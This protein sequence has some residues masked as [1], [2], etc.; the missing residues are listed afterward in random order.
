MSKWEAD[1]V[2]VVDLAGTE[3]PDSRTVIRCKF[4]L[5]ELADE[6]HLVFG[7]L[8]D[9]PYHARLVAQFCSERRIPSGWEHEPD[10]YAL[11]TANARVCGGGYLAIDPACR[12]AE[13]YGRSNA[14]GPYDK[15]AMHAVVEHGPVFRGLTV[16]VR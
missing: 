14:Y 1:R 16:S 4:V 6:I 8:A 5:I 15:K 9:Y 2:K 7:R 3:A 13:V 12:T 10:L 11:Y